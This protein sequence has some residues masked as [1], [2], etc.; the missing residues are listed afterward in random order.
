MRAECANG[1]LAWHRHQWLQLTRRFVGQCT[2]YY[3]GTKMAGRKLKP[4]HN[5]EHYPCHNPDCQRGTPLALRSYGMYPS[6]DVPEAKVHRVYE[7][8]MGSFSV[9]CSA[10]GHYTIVSPH[11][12]K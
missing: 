9:A 5:P 2:R 3:E 1:T 10:C 11:R 4:G 6:A 7:P 8:Q 12:L